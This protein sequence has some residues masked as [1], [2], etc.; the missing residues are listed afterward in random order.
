MLRNLLRQGIKDVAAGRDPKGII[1]DAARA[2]NVATSAGSTIAVQETARMF[3]RNSWYVAAWSQDVNAQTP[4][5]RTILDE[6]VVLFRTSDGKVNAL[7]GRCA[8]R[9][10]PL[11]LPNST[12]TRSCAVITV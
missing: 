3:I 10:M 7:E 9:G 1:R 11:R 4:L 8:H 5:G 6:P 12:A 2:A